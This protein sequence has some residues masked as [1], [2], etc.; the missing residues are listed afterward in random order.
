MVLV[1]EIE[2]RSHWLGRPFQLPLPVLAC[3]AGQRLRKQMGDDLSQGTLLAFLKRLELLENGGVN[4]ERRS[5]HDA[6]MLSPH[7]SHV[8]YWNR[9]LRLLTRDHVRD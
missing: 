1:I 8:K 7:A 9:D 3:S 2:L 4:V 5:R 6:L